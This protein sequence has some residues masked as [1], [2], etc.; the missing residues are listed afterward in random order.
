MILGILLKDPFYLYY[1]HVGRKILFFVFFE[2]EGP[3]KTQKD[4]RFFY[5]SFYGKSGPGELEPHLG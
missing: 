3:S 1:N 5:K 2:F 4:L